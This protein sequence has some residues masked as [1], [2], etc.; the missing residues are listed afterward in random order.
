MNTV[1]MLEAK[2]SLS[3]LVD[4]AGDRPTPRYPTA[5]TA[6]PRR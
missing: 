4:A 6:A 2:S 3:R 1:N 5:L